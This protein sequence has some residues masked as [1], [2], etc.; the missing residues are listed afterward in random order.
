MVEQQ[1]GSFSST[2]NQNTDVEFDVYFH[3]WLVPVSEPTWISMKVVAF[4]VYHS[5]TQSEQNVWNWCQFLKNWNLVHSRMER[6]AQ[7]P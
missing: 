3:S 4:L 1:P 5:R 2:Q 7:Q 6:L